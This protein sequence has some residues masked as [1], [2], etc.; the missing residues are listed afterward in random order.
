[1]AYIKDGTLLEGDFE[2]KK[3]KQ[4]APRYWLL[5]KASFTNAYIQVHTY[6]VFILRQ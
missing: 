1:M 3:V 4:K 5:R 6:Y 2:A